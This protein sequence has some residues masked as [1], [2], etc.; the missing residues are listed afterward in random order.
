MTH[1]Y[2]CVMELV[3]C[4]SERN[5]HVFFFLFTSI[6]PGLYQAPVET[7]K[8]KASCV[9]IEHRLCGEEVGTARKKITIKW[10][11]FVM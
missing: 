5:Q 8:H 9:S 11:Q 2:F 6:S 1:D 4:T 3:I 10:A 7:C